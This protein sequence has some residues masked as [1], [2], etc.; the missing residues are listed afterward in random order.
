MSKRKTNIVDIRLSEKVLA[1]V[2]RLQILGE[3]ADKFRADFLGHLVYLGTKKYPFELK[4]QE[5]DDKSPRI[6]RSSQRAAKT[7]S[8]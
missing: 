3:Y 7:G 4:T 5:Q 6:G 1:E 8:K 2:E